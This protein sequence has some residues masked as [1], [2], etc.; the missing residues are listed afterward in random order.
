MKLA[1]VFFSLLFCLS[2]SAVP[3]DF[4]HTSDHTFVSPVE[5]PV[6]YCYPPSG[7]PFGDYFSSDKCYYRFND[8]CSSAKTISFDHNNTDPGQTQKNKNF[9]A[10]C[11]DMKTEEGPQFVF[12][13]EPEA[14]PS[15]FT[16]KT[17]ILL[18]N[19]SQ[20]A[21]SQAK[22]LVFYDIESDPSQAIHVPGCPPNSVAILNLQ[23][24]T[25]SQNAT[26]KVACQG[27]INT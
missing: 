8:T 3:L 11:S 5:D 27:H 4:V 23:A 25:T 16:V 19:Q 7:Q 22:L 24:P 13:V 20:V 9:F 6:D 2:T 10:L 15:N 26:Y 21:P 18:P 12:Y 1:L 14:T 17:C